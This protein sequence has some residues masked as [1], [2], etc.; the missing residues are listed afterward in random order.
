MGSME[1][2][3]LHLSYNNASRIE[4]SPSHIYAIANGSLFSYDRADGTLNYWNRS[5][6]LNGMTVVD[7]AYDKIASELIIVYD[8]GRID[9][10]RENGEVQHMPDLYMKAGSM[11]V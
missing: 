8:D 1:Q 9:L 11:A 4:A 3:R 7:I 6:G 2:W 10:M 5:N